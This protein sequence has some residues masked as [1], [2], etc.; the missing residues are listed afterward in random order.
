GAMK[1]K[2]NQ[3]YDPLMANNVCVAGQLLLLDLIEHLEPHCQLIQSNTDGLF[4]KINHEN[5]LDTI[6][7]ICKEWEQRTR[8]E[9]EFDIFTKIFQKDVNNY[10]VINED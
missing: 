8:M 10:I 3:L 5:D 6:K 9:L 2:Y 4:V 7:E 1:D